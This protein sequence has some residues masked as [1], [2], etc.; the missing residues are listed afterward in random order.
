MPN[1]ILFLNENPLP[2]IFSTTT[3][4]GKE[5]RL[6]AMLDEIDHIHVIAFPG[7]V[8]ESSPEV[9]QREIEK[10]IIIH[11]LTSWPYY[12]RWIPLFFAGWWH[13][14]K[15]RPLVV[16]AESPIISGIAAILIKKTTQAKV[17]IEVRASYDQL[18]HFR[19]TAIPVAIK[20][21]L[22]QRVTDWVYKNAD[23]IIANSHHYQK[24][25]PKACSSSIINPGIS[26]T[27]HTHKKQLKIGYMG[28]LVKEKGVDHLLKATHHIKE[29]LIEKNI[30]VEIAGDGPEREELQRMTK[31]LRIEKLVTFIG[32]VPNISTLSTWKIAINPN[33]VNHPLEM[34]NI[35]AASVATPVISYGTKQ[36]P[37]TVEHNHTGLVVNTGEI[38][39]L[40][41]AIK[42]LVSNE[43]RRAQYGKNAVIFA[44]KYAIEKQAQRLRSTYKQLG[45]L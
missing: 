32:M 7:M 21:Y 11:R 28:R 31:V 17:V 16:E 6:R 27:N 41:A 30:R 4:S 42:Q 43:K 26:I 36:L 1:T 29:F 22:L 13:A 20:K 25:I 19:A 23:H 44:K 14:K 8:V 2:R 18:L 9:A 37:E 40:A 38:H 5:L 15:I 34:T 35:E 33:L 12:L 39:L 3:V 10:K 45:I 24:R